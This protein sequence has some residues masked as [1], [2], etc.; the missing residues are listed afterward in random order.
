M[1]LLHSSALFACFL[2]FLALLAGYPELRLPS[3]TEIKITETETKENTDSNLYWKTGSL[4]SLFLQKEAL[5]LFEEELL[6]GDLR[7]KEI[8]RS[9]RRSFIQDIFLLCLNLLWFFLLGLCLL[10]VSAKHHFLDKLSAFLLLSTVFLLSGNLL[11]LY[12]EVKKAE[13]SMGIPSFSLLSIAQVVVLLSSLTSLLCRFFSKSP[14]RER[15]S[16]FLK[17][18]TFSL[19]AFHFSLICLGALLLANV[20]LFPLYALQISFP[21]F[22]ALFLFF[23]LLLLLGYYSYAH[24]SMLPGTTGENNF[25]LALSLLAYRS[26]VKS[27]FFLSIFFI[28]GIIGG[29]IILITVYNV[30]FLK[31]LG[32][33]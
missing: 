33:Y 28:L 24:R 16:S 9:L 18:K 1:R 30:G 15:A 32:N 7:P 14:F 12:S 11:L 26:M 27:L 22:F 21:A 23:F 6:E 5:A 10:N 4:K 31:A 8:F 19:F 25:F 29:S 20:F 17:A 2:Y 3:P 13:E